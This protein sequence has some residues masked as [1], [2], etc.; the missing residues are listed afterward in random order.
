MGNVA[1]TPQW[2]GTLET[3][4]QTL[5]VDAWKR[6]MD[7][8]MWDKMMDVRKSG[9]LRELLFWLIESAKI[10]TEGLGGNKRYDDIA[11]TFQE[12]D[13]TRSGAGLILTKDEI[14][15]NMMAS[16]AM[17]GM[18]PLDYA[19]SWA[20]Q[21]GGGAAYWPQERLFT[22]LIG[23]GKVTTGPAGSCYDGQ[24]FFSASHPVNPL[25]GGPTFSNIATAKPLSAAADLP[26]A[27][28]NINAVVAQMRGF[29]MPN[30][31]YRFMRP[32]VLMYDPSNDYTVSQLL[33]AK[34]FAATE[35]A[36]FSRLKLQPICCDELAAEPGVYYIGAEIIPG[37][38][39]PFI[40]Q[41][42]EP[43]VLSSYAPETLVEL[44]RRKKFEWDFS[45]RN[46]VAY[47]H[48]FQIIR[49]EPT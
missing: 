20:R 5:A 23:F 15:D 19:A 35:N 24:A 2:V 31:K 47:G 6:V 29:K 30:G 9:T 39:G 40:Y 22:D 8:L 10:S 37:E 16:G 13:N 41:D 33:D 48:P 11:A 18:S 32:R 43:Y 14:A 49:V 44:Q 4:V 28:A 26:T 12:I 25:G 42:R 46:A 45:G 1:V 21:M 34:F 7:E 27:A 38:G 36:Y 3:N 17:R